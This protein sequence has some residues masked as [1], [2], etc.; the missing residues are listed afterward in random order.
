MLNIEKLIGR[1]L[2][3]RI[4]NNS[5]DFAMAF[6]EK[7]LVATVSCIGFGCKDF[8]RLTYAAS[9]EDIV[10]GMNRLEEFIGNRE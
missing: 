5:D 8:I 10:K 7:G 6:L 9:M 1:E 3:G 2:G 4:I